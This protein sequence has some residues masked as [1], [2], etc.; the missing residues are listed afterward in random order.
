M[1][2][3]FTLFKVRGIAIGVN[4]SWGSHLKTGSG[5][6]TSTSIL[7][8]HDDTERVSKPSGIA[9]SVGAGRPVLERRGARPEGGGPAPPEAQLKDAIEV[10]KSGGRPSLDTG[11]FPLGRG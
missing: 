6:R 2:S 3:S 1:E 8:E 11:W 4:W 10:F 7:H 5:C 9:A